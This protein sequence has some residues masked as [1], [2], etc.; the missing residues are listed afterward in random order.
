MGTHADRGA[1]EYPDRSGYPDG[2][3]VLDEGTVALIDEVTAQALRSVDRPSADADAE[4][5]VHRIAERQVYAA[6]IDGREVAS[7]RYATG[8][9]TVVVLTTTVDADFRG[10]GI[11][12][13]LIADALD[14]LRRTGESLIVRCQVVA[15]FIETN[16][17]YADLAVD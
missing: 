8:D 12:T 3:G 7:L 5:A 13:A 11:A 6:T 14:D 16:P 10:R 15:A 17:Q 1:F 2:A 4:V 9:G